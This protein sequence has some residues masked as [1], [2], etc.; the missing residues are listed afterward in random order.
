MTPKEAQVTRLHYAMTVQFIRIS[1]Q[2]QATILAQ[3]I[4]IICVA[5]L[6]LHSLKR[7]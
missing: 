4:Y 6:S 7:H 2:I 5:F 3:A 1:Q